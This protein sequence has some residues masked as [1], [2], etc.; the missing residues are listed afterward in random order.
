LDKP[1]AWASGNKY[2]KLKR[3]LS[4]AAAAGVTSIVSKGGMFSNHLD[5]L[6]SA[7]TYHH[8]GL[9]CIVRSYQGD[10]EG[11]TISRLRK[12][13][14]EVEFLPPDAYAKYDEATAATHH[15]SSL[16]IPE[17]GLSDQGIAGVQELGQFIASL[18]FNHVV[19]AGGSLCTAMG[20]MA[21]ANQHMHL[22]IMPAWKGSA[23]D[24]VKRLMAQYQITTSSTW[25]LWPD[26]H[27]GGFGKWNTELYEFMTHFTNT[28]RIPLDP[29]YTGKLMFALNRRL[30]R[31]EFTSRDRILVIHT[32]GLQGVDGYAYRFSDPWQQYLDLI[33]G[34][35]P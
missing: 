3:T 15:P 33:S 16:F 34:M 2:F 11:P 31:N 20:L 32:G 1:G 29:V 5:A 18:D 25:D 14:A 26:E 7:C 4:G 23:M 27:L 12:H 30:E 22:H 19:V 21:E 17:G 6:A 13:G 28:T 24:D 8:L 10:L 35:D 9:T